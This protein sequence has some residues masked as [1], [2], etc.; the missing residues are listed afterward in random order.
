MAGGVLVVLGL[1]MNEKVHN[2]RF[3]GTGM[4]GGKMYIRGKVRHLGEE[5]AISEL[6]ESDNLVLGSLIDEYCNYFDIN[7]KKI[8]ESSFKKVF[9]V[10]TR[11]Y[12]NIYAY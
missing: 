5:V 1:N 6:N 8:L 4:H 11:P 7:R 2:A 3:V 12:G 9:P 10:S